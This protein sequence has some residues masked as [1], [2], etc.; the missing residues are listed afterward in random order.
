MP[1]ETLSSRH[2]RSGAVPSVAVFACRRVLLSADSEHSPSRPAIASPYSRTSL[3]PRNRPCPHSPSPK[4]N[5]GKNASRSQAPADLTVPL[6]LLA[7][8][9][10]RKAEPVRIESCAAGL[11]SAHWQDGPVPQPALRL[12]A[13]ARECPLTA[14]SSAPAQ[15]RC[16]PLRSSSPDRTEDP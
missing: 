8:C 16:I 12:D 14:L 10:G 3:S 13:P 11:V 5:T 1:L 4:K 2:A 9:E 15:L 7:D 6:R